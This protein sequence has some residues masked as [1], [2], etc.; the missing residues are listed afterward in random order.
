M[1]DTHALL[2]PSSSDRWL[3]CP[4]SARLAETII[5]AVGQDETPYAKRGTILH[6]L[7]AK[8]LWN[9]LGQLSADALLDAVEEVSLTPEESQMVSK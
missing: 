3:H 5:S 2:S 7:A 8:S 1:P 4:A 6:D 9:K